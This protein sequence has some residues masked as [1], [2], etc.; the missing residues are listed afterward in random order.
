MLVAFLK[1]KQNDW[2]QRGK[3]DAQ[4]GKTSLC[5]NVFPDYRYANLEL[6]MTR[7]AAEND[8]A[9]FLRAFGNNGA[10]IDEAQRVPELF[11]AA[12]VLVDEDRS[13]KFV[14]TGSSNFL[15]MKN[16]SQSLAGR[17]AIT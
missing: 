17:V 16:I 3:T 6:A 7:T 11:S 1:E 13:R 15:L 8:P 12:Q 10:I 14:F 2:E 9:A 4:S 5:K